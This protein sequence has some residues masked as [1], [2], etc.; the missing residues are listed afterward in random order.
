[1]AHALQSG[2]HEDLDGADRQAAEGED[3]DEHAHPAS[4]QGADEVADALGVGRQPRETGWLENAAVPTSQH[5]PHAII[6][7]RVD[8]EPMPA[9]MTTG[10][11][12]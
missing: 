10:P 11:Q 8:H 3:G 5:R 9:T 12:M 1:M 6:A 2:G 4:A 7:A